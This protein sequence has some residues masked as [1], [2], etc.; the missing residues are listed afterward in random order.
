MRNEGAQGDLGPTWVGRAGIFGRNALVVGLIVL[1]TALNASIHLYV[2]AL[3]GWLPAGL[4]LSLLLLLGPSVLPGVVTGVFAGLLLVGGGLMVAG[5][6]AAG[7]ALAVYGVWR[8]VC[9]GRSERALALRVATL[10]RVLLVGAAAF[11]IVAVVFD[12]KAVTGMLAPAWLPAG[13]GAVRHAHDADDTAHAA[14]H[15]AT[16]SAHAAARHGESSGAVH[17]V[18]DDFLEWILSEAIGVMLVV[19]LALYAFRWRAEAGRVEPRQPQAWLVLFALVTTTTAIYSGFIENQFGIVHTTLLVLPPAV[20]LA[21]EFGALYTLV[22]NFVVL[23]ITG[24][25]TALGHGPFKDHS[26]GLPIL[27]VVYLFTTLM[28]LASSAERRQAGVEIR[29]LALRDG[30]T[31]LPNRKAFLERVDQALAAAQRHGRRLGLLFIDLDDFKTVNDTLGHAAGDRL[32]VEVTDRLQACMRRDSTLARFGGDELIVL[33]EHID[34]DESLRGVAARIADAMTAP[35]VLAGQPRRV[36]CSIGISRFPVDGQNSAEL[37]RKA[38]IAMYEVK[39]SGRN[40]YRVY[41]H[42][43]NRFALVDRREQAG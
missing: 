32:L 29:R 14:S 24:V 1:L 4:A 9:P 11:V 35:F 16:P 7:T 25:G 42:G 8:F 43:M 2:P 37:L 36:S 13:A 10:S 33:V 39:A 5:A 12:G 34:G 21:L 6:H 27:S 23:S 40:G 18:R 15:G 22:G 38:D 26:A 31:G 28:I 19:P 41:E 17:A 20:W 30:L 3:I